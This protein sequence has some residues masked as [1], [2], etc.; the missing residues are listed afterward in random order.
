M[1]LVVVVVVVVIAIVV[2]AIVIEGGGRG[3]KDKHVVEEKQEM[4]GRDMHKPGSLE[5]LKP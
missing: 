1:A 5:L 4:G 2:I 3:R